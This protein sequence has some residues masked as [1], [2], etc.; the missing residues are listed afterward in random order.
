VLAAGVLVSKT[1]QARASVSAWFV[2]RFRDGLISAVE[3]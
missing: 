1:R 2:Y 3:T